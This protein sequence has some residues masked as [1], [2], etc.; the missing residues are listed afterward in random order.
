MPRARRYVE[1]VPVVVRYGFGDLVGALHLTPY[2]HAAIGIPKSG[3][4]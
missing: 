3:R 2:L 1:I 4:V